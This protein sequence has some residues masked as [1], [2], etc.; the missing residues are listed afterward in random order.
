MSWVT[1]RRY[2]LPMEAH[3]D[4]G[5]LESEGIQ[6]IIADEHTI[7]MQW[8]YSNALGGVR[9]QVDEGD[10]ERAERVLSEDRSDVV[11]ESLAP[12]QAYRDTGEAP[13]LSRLARDRSRKGFFAALLI[14]LFGT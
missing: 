3:L 10:V 8:L 13:R 4:R 11:D 5:R 12:G 14:W 9:L 7:H 6:A 1:L 2:T